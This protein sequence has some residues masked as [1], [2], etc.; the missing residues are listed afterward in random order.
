MVKFLLKERIP[1]DAINNMSDEYSLEHNNYDFDHIKLKEEQSFTDIHGLLYPPVFVNE[2]GKYVTAAGKRVI[3]TYK[4]I[5]KDVPYGLIID[6][7]GNKY[8]FLKFLI[9]M[10]K[11]HAGLNVI[12]KS[13]ALKKCFCLREKIEEEITVLLGIPKNEMII[14]H[15]IDLADASENIKTLILSGKLHEN[16]AFEIFS[17]MREE[18]DL[19]AE[20]ISALFLGTKKRNK[21]INMVY[22][23]SQREET[24]VK[25]LIEN[26]E[27][28]DILNSHVD[29]PQVGDR[30][31]TYFEEMRYPVIYKYRKN[32]NKK[33]N[34]VGFDT[35]MQVVVPRDFELRE[36]KLTFVFSSAGDFNDQIRKLKKIG[37]SGPFKKLM[38]IK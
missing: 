4:R 21:I 17:F 7:S 5:N 27:I 10:K 35:T 20:F 16:T 29:P 19:L 24:G 3:A 30:I 1:V 9:H 32:F 37:E 36:F 38:E 2:S 18:W 31:F 28:Y 11:E 8:D 6:G 33:L 25:A 34:D 14:Q 22:E 26:D 13:N 15:Y 23:I 12:E